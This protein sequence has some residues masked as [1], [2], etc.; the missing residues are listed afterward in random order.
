MGQTNNPLQWL[1][2]L[3]PR[4]EVD[5]TFQLMGTLLETGETVSDGN[6]ALTPSAETIAAGLI[7]GS[8]PYASSLSGTQLTF[9]FSVA[10]AHVDDVAFNGTGIWLDFDLEVTT[11][12][13]PPRIRNRTL[14]LRVARQ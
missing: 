12:N 3:D 1:Q 2:P 11:N 6:W 7:V 5:Y 4:D 14:L 8:G 13:T 10:P 9:W